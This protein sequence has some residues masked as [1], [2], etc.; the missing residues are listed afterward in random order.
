MLAL[1]A[2]LATA[3]LGSQAPLPQTA[4]DTDAGVRMTIDG[5]RLT[6]TFEEERAARDV[7]GRPVQALCATGLDRLG[8][9][10]APAESDIAFVDAVW[11]ADALTATFTLPRAVD[12][13]DVCGL[14]RPGG[15]DIAW[16]AFSELARRGRA[17]IER[18]AARE[19]LAGAAKAARRRLCD[20]RRPITDRGLVRL[21]REEQP[22]QVFALA[23]NAGD[24]THAGVIYV[25]ASRST[26]R[27]ITLVTRSPDGAAFFRRVRR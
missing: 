2:A 20:R 16:V 11:P 4:L 6:V 5:A 7:Q 1:V 19:R 8:D 24:V 23:R 13:V 17:G 25:L 3:A 21:L 26:K 9:S 27:R 12:P 15:E 22:G 18:E 14:E 10:G